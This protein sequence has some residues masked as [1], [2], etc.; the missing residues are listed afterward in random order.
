MSVCSR[1]S[2]G[3]PDPLSPSPSTSW[4]QS[5]ANLPY[6][7]GGKAYSLI[8]N[9]GRNKEEVLLERET[10]VEGLDPI[11]LLLN[12]KMPNCMEVCDNALSKIFEINSTVCKTI[13]VP[14]VTLVHSVLSCYIP[15]CRHCIYQVL[16]AV[17]N[18]C[19][20]P[21]VLDMLIKDH[22]RRR[23]S[24]TVSPTCLIGLFILFHYLL[25]NKVIIFP[26]ETSLFGKLTKYVA[27]GL[28]KTFVHNNSAENIIC[29]S[30][31]L[32]GDTQGASTTLLKGLAAF[33]PFEIFESDFD[34]V[35]AVRDANLLVAFAERITTL[36]MKIYERLVLVL[37][38]LCFFPPSEIEEWFKA[39]DAIDVLYKEDNA[40]C[41]LKKKLARY[42]TDRVV[43]FELYK[44]GRQILL[45]LEQGQVQEKLL[46][47]VK[48]KVASLKQIIVTNAGAYVG[49]ESKVS[50]LVLFMFGEPGVG[51]TILCDH[52][53]RDVFAVL[54][55]EPYN[56]AVDKYPYNSLSAYHDTYMYQRVFECQDIF[57]MSDKQILLN[58]VINVMKIGD[59]SAYAMNIA[60]CGNKG[61]MFF[62]S[63]FVYLTS[64]VNI[65]KDSI[66]LHSAMADPNAFLRRIDLNVM[67][68]RSESAGP[69]TKFSRDTYSFHVNKRRYTYNE[70][71]VLIATSHLAK[72]RKSLDLLDINNCFDQARIGLMKTMLDKEIGEPLLPLDIWCDVCTGTS[73]RCHMCVE[74]KR[75][76]PYLEGEWKR[77]SRGG[78]FN[79]L[80]RNDKVHVCG[81]CEVAATKD[82]HLSQLKP[83]SKY[84]SRKILT[85]GEVETKADVYPYHFS[86]D[87]LLVPST[88]NGLH[89]S[90]SKPSSFW[91]SFPDSDNDITCVPIP[92][93]NVYA[94]IEKPYLWYLTK[95][96]RCLRPHSYDPIVEVRKIIESHEG[97]KEI[98]E[99]FLKQNYEL[100]LENFPCTGMDKLLH[101]GADECAWVTARRMLLNAI[102]IKYGVRLEFNDGIRSFCYGSP[103]AFSIYDVTFDLISCQVVKRRVS[104]LLLITKFLDTVEKRLVRFKE[105]F[106]ANHPG[107]WYI[108]FQNPLSQ[109]LYEHK[110]GVCAFISALM[111]IAGCVRSLLKC[112]SNLF[113]FGTNVIQGLQNDSGSPF[114]VKNR[115]MVKTKGPRAAKVLSQGGLSIDS[116]SNVVFR[117]LGKMSAAGLTVNC[118]ALEQHIILAPIH[119]LTDNDKD[120]YYVTFPSYQIASFSVHFKINEVDCVVCDDNHTVI[121]NLAPLSSMK[122]IRSFPSIMKHVAEIEPPILEGTGALLMFKVEN[123][124]WKE[125]CVVVSDIS[126]RTERVILT[127]QKTARKHCAEEMLTY[128][129]ITKSG[130]CG[131]VLMALVGSTWKVMGIHCGMRE[132]TTMGFGSFLTR[133]WLVDSILLVNGIPEKIPL[134]SESMQPVTLEAIAQGLNDVKPFVHFAPVS[135][136]GYLDKPLGHQPHS[137][138]I[139]P[140]VLSHW[141]NIE[142]TTG[143]AP[144]IGL[145]NSDYGLVSPLTKALMKWDNKS[146]LIHPL[147]IDSV[148]GSIVNDYMFDGQR[149]FVLS[150]EEAVFGTGD[151]FIK[152]IDHSASVGYPWSLHT[153]RSKL[154]R[155]GEK[156]IS[157][158]LIMKVD[159]DIVKLIECKTLDFVVVD[160][161]K[162]ER[163]PLPKVTE[164]KARLFSI[165]PLHVNLILKMYFGIF[166]ETVIANC[167]TGV[168]KI[169]FSPK[170]K[171]VRRFA[172]DFGF[173][174]D[175][176]DYLCGDIQSSD[177]V[178]PYEVFS[179]LTYKVNQ[180]YERYGDREQNSMIRTALSKVVFQPWHAV[181]KTIIRTYQGMPSGCY[182]T[183]VFNSLA[184]A[185]LLKQFLRELY[186]SIEEDCMIATYGDDHIVK[187]PKQSFTCFQLRNWF[188]HLNIVYTSPEKD[189][190]LKE[191]Y[192]RHDVTFLKRRFVKDMFWKMPMEYTAIVENIM[193]IHKNET[194]RKWSEKFTAFTLLEAAAYELVHHTIEKWEEFFGIFAP[195]LTK[196]NLS[197]NREHYMLAYKDSDR[198]DPPFFIGFFDIVPTEGW[199]I[200]P[201]EQ[202]GE[203]VCTPLPKL[204][205][206][207]QV[208]TLMEGEVCYGWKNDC[209]TQAGDNIDEPSCEKEAIILG[210]PR[211]ELFTVDSGLT[212]FVDPTPSSSLH[213]PSEFPKPVDVS[214]EW[215][216]GYCKQ[217]ERTVL[218]YGPYVLNQTVMTGVPLFRFAI[219][220]FLLSLPYISNR[221]QNATYI[222]FDIEVNIRVV[223][224]KFHYGAL[225]ALFR[226]CYYYNCAGSLAWN[227]T[228]R[229][230]V[231]A[232][233]EPYDTIYT[234]STL[235]HKLISLTGDTSCT[236]TMEWP[237]PV[238][239]MLVARLFGPE[240]ATFDPFIFDIYSLSPTLPADIDPPELYVTCTMRNVKLHGY[241][242]THE[243]TFA[244]PSNILF[245]SDVIATSTWTSIVDA[246]LWT[247][248]PGVQEL[249]VQEDGNEKEICPFIEK[250]ELSLVSCG[251]LEGITQAEDSVEVSLKEDNKWRRKEFSV[252]SMLRNVV[253]IATPFLSVLDFFGLSKPRDPHQ[254]K[255]MAVTY[256]P[257]A[258]S[259]GVDPCTSVAFDRTCVLDEVKGLQ[260]MLISDI[261][262]KEMLMWAGL[263]KNSG[264]VVTRSMSPKYGMGVEWMTHGT[265]FIPSPACFIAN[266]FHYWRASVRLT[267]RIYSSAML[268]CRFQLSFE[269]YN[270]RTTPSPQGLVS[271]ACSWIFEGT[272]DFVR[273]FTIPFLCENPFSP[274]HRDYVNVSLTCLT[275]VVSPE[276]TES[277]PI[278]I[279]MWVSFP[280]L[281]VMVP[282]FI[283]FYD[284]VGTLVPTV[285]LQ[286]AP[287]K[288]SDSESVLGLLAADLECPSSDG[289]IAY[290]VITQAGDELEAIGSQVG[291][292]VIHGVGCDIP[293][294][295]L[296]LVKRPSW[297]VTFI[298]GSTK[299]KPY[300]VHVRPD[301]VFPIKLQ[302]KGKDSTFVRYACFGNYFTYF[303]YLFVFY[304]TSFNVFSQSS[305][306]DVVTAS[307]HQSY[308]STTYDTPK[309][310]VKRNLVERELAYVSSFVGRTV[311]GSHV[312]FRG[313]TYAAMCPTPVLPDNDQ[314]KWDYFFNIQHDVPL[315]NAGFLISPESFIA[316]CAADD[317]NFYV[318]RG[319]P[320]M[321]LI[322]P[323]A[324][325][326]TLTL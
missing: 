74:L 142:K 274:F 13:L 118:L 34:Q 243:V 219:G 2:G 210:N 29:Q 236:M 58:E 158:E 194:T 315:T 263:V 285:G 135:V 233:W 265:E 65:G 291:G 199:N 278:W 56:P 318:W 144:L 24:F 35:K 275:D 209:V 312:P 107:Y 232:H 270:Q 178:I 50:P 110:T 252:S 138:K 18:G 286:R 172:L 67:V 109:W 54:D 324:I 254:P 299:K 45:K 283:Q 253:K 131:A 220:S 247:L 248:P 8:K 231:Q 53:F 316:T 180:W 49:S 208:E 64:N 214:F 306:L 266:K 141:H 76:H 169:G 179:V 301:T 91:E 51:K 139:V 279:T 120:D 52:L 93:H 272:G 302:Y 72:Q 10:G 88:S 128:T 241:C 190:P 204:V 148:A 216:E 268:T 203:L 61:Q 31:V 186:P 287:G 189:K 193:W 43:L 22:E 147:R 108:L 314:A 32:E 103:N 95:D 251:E 26:I 175:D 94:K 177:R 3:L 102:C 84:R 140:S 143:P 197:F 188:A 57:Q 6:K 264:F 87:G 183:A 39:V 303:S 161:L 48:E 160:M 33:L 255:V 46:R 221:V 310:Y 136:E 184:Y 130:D 313:S 159:R 15:I 261:A 150:L 269:Y 81:K 104:I 298:D 86:H 292:G 63:D 290:D 12:S 258:N 187:V 213:L 230:F 192:N 114:T 262:Q 154:I 191:V 171:S 68:T 101:L 239:Y 223:A 9:F 228:R 14:V 284:N 117:N 75:T 90:E 249:E 215:T 153:N 282:S 151:G 212:R 304:R 289:E 146:S 28:T 5:L 42:S 226:P 218:L 82:T 71:V 73:D 145:Y 235:P 259:V 38:R 256:L 27:T 326:T 165:L 115:K 36:F 80:R 79:E 70:F 317:C 267:L 207:T 229:D 129:A 201:G 17:L 167:S 323:T 11:D 217:L 4:N 321:M 127:D 250:D 205:R 60:E 234:A 47:T 121:I 242:A 163:L 21:F 308:M 166:C 44:K 62:Q 260:S 174:T 319:V 98:D 170:Y 280:D 125:N 273:C 122:S 85:Q 244:R 225:M 206:D 126:T 19:P 322:D 157:S 113:S 257:I 296:H 97:E 83:S 78:N 325:P 156:W 155:F 196:F 297:A 162:D 133:D 295:I 111:I 276:K 202:V 37:E 168:V 106:A 55:Y 100:L 288:L 119:I 77:V 40:F 23:T 320:A 200:F 311:F 164:G 198:L 116:V 173:D 181:G 69:E 271:N 294:S 176:F 132:K 238:N 59:E 41:T 281:Q 89:I 96:Q 134:P 211:G 182:L 112:C 222:R 305:M 30:E 149:A 309:T 25:Y 224:T 245:G 7:L 20:F 237:L 293:T 195:V 300:S 152:D 185:I 99:V 66:L 227:D 105:S 123:G 124:I 1:L 246:Q 92:D 277:R 137:S 307:H 16:N 240:G